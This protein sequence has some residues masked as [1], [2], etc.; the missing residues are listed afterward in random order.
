MHRWEYGT[1]LQ[2]LLEL[3]TPEL[4]VLTQPNASTGSTISVPPPS[5]SPP[6]SLSTVLDVVATII[7]NRSQTISSQK[8]SEPQSFFPSDGAAG[9]PAS[10]GVA[11]LLANY[12][13][14][15]NDSYDPLAAAQSQLQFLL[16][17][18]PRAEN[19]A[20]SHRVSEVQLWSDFVYMVPPFLTYY[21]VMSGNETLAGMGYDQI[22]AYREQLRDEKTGLWLHVVNGR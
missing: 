16:E 11:A 9:D 17:K 20:I 2:A 12:T 19:G 21:G 10:V 13:G 6:S 18:V 4:S 22:K 1:R 8:L 14:Q 7:A 5:T 3:S 15:K